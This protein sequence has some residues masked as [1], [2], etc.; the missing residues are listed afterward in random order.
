L[1][2]PPIR[3]DPT[4]GPRSRRVP[5]RVSVSIAGGRP[6]ESPSTPGTRSKF[7]RFRRRKGAC[8]AAGR[9]PLPE[10][11]AR[12]GA[13]GSIYVPDRPKYPAAGRCRRTGRFPVPTA[14]KHRRRGF[15]A[16]RHLF[17]VDRGHSPF[18]REPLYHDPLSG[19]PG[20]NRDRPPQAFSRGCYGLTHDEY[21]TK[22]LY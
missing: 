18:D 15:A 9:D 5:L 13:P 3:P 19:N 8:G 7:A 6:G 21:P 16:I 11:V 12:P 1:R 20:L 4:R 2:S 17:G 10:A 14:R 22:H